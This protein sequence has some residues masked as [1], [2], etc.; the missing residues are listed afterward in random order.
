MHGGSVLDTKHINKILEINKRNLIARAEC[1][2]VPSSLLCDRMPHIGTQT[3]GR[4][5]KA[6]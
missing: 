4:E 1:G 2:I 5:A 3:D 6:L